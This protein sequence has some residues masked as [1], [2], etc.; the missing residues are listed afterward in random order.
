[1][2]VLRER[3]TFIHKI[4]DFFAQRAVLEVETPLLSSAANTS[5]HIDSFVTR[6]QGP[7]A[8]TGQDYYLHTSPEFPMKRLLA[9]GSGAIYQICKVFRNGELGSRHNPEFTM[10]EWYRPNWH[11]HQLMDELIELLQH[12]CAVSRVERISYEQLFRQFFDIDIHVAGC[13]QLA[14]TGRSRLLARPAD[15]SLY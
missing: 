7:G 12:V 11:Y 15:E 4:R 3:A 13:S 6:Y 1:M 10:L 9:A 5:P 2:D 14:T 8:A